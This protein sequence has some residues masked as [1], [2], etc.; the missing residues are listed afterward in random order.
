MQNYFKKFMS[1]WMSLRQTEAE[2]YLSQAIDAAD[3][4]AR[5]QYLRD[6]GYAV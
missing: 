4:K 5:M 3:L 2:H 1:W 6:R